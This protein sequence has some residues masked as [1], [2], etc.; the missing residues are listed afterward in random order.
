MNSKQESMFNHLKHLQA[1]GR[2]QWVKYWLEY[3]NIDTW[4]FWFLLALFLIPLIVIYL[5]INRN[6]ALLLGFFGYN[7]H[8][9]FT[10]LDALGTTE[11][12]WGYP[13]KFIPLLPSSFTLDVSLVPAAYMF[14]YQWVLKKKKNYFI[15][16]IILSAI[17]AFIFKPLLVYLNLF[18]FFNGT[19]Y[20]HLFLAYILVGAVSKIVTNVFIYLEKK[21]KNNK[22]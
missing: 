22:G 3:S 8:V 1:E 13:Y 17:F 7:V 2:D 14:L 5:F 20:L 4:Q 9:F 11:S 6:N 18:V 10:Y 12:Y 15:Y 19:N 16:M 21:A